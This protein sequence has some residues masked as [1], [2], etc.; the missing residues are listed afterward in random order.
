[1]VVVRDQMRNDRPKEEC[2]EHIDLPKSW[3]VLCQH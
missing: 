3:W 1:M 2:F